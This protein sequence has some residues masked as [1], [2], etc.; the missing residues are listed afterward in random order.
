MND[1]NNINN[2]LA[3]RFLTKAVKRDPFFANNLYNILYTGGILFFEYRVMIADN[4]TNGRCSFVIV[5][6][7]VETNLV[8]Y[9]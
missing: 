5:T 8:F 4:V 6:I 7:I 3:A 2:L 1:K 9:I